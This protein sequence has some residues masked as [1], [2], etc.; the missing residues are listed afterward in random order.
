[1]TRRPL[2]NTGRQAVCTPAARFA[3]LDSVDDMDLYAEVNE[4]GA[5]QHYTTS[6]MAGQL[7]VPAW[8]LRRELEILELAG[9]VRLDRAAHYRLIPADQVEAVKE[10][11]RERGLLTEVVAATAAG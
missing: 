9:K 3:L 4:M 5:R 2:E 11:L 1:V 7:G 10:W 8:R 6:E